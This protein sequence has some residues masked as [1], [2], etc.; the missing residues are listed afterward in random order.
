MFKS[1][2]LWRLYSAFAAVIL[3][4]ALIINVLLGNNF[5]RQ[6]AK[7]LD[8]NLVIRAN[9]L[10]ELALPYLKLNQNSEKLAELQDKISN[11]DV[12]VSS[13][14]TVFNQNGD[15]LADSRKL[16][17]QMDNH[18]DR[19]EIRQALT[20]P[21]GETE[22]FSDSL[23]QIMRYKAVA[24]IEDGRLLGFVRVALPLND[25]EARQQVLTLY[26]LLGCMLAAVVAMFMGF[27]FARRF[28]KP[29]I[30][31]THSAE[32][33]AQGDYQQRVYVAN[34]DEIGKLAHAFNYMAGSAYERVQRITEDR[35]KLATILSGLIE[36]VIAVDE[37]HN[38][39]HINE[40][41]S[42]MLNISISASIGHSIWSSVPIVEVHE[43]LTKI[44]REGGVTEIQARIPKQKQDTVIEVYGA[45][46]E[47]KNGRYGAI[48]VLHD[49]SELEMLE[50]IRRDFVTNASHELK[51]PLT[52]IRGIV[53]TILNDSDMDKDT[54]WHFL[55]RVQGQTDRLVSIVSDLMTLSRLESARNKDFSPVSIKAVINQS[56]K[57]FASIAAEKSVYLQNELKQLETRDFK[58]LGDAHA[59][60]QLFDN[61][62]DNAIKYT[63]AHGSISVNA[64]IVDENATLL[65]HVSDTGLGINTANQARVFERFYRVDKGRSRELGGTGLG[66]AI[67]K[68]IAEQHKGRITLSSTLGKG[69]CF[70]VSL[71][72]L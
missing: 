49:I 65:V 13:R 61:L 62:I 34:T 22:R 39:I 24:I 51:T 21:F 44:L 64:E 7:Q 14:L 50:N 32:A 53:E 26:I 33:I 45:A 69:S 30:A 11:I 31:L 40:A 57:S 36:G 12:Q 6:E 47:Q 35:N 16:P 10:K 38:I 71:P 63:P 37:H 5:A 23:Q 20:H 25:I 66:L 28:A 68:H 70:T 4:C 29:I 46:L 27:L 1:S 8:E 18:L 17:S 43:L 54:L 9:F 19:I 15:V 55:H 48:L 52:A 42:R 72:K 59:L 56:L 58:V 67:C 41:A 3:I 2:F 60:G